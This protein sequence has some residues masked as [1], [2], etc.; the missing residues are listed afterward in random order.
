MSDSEEIELPGKEKRQ[1][2]KRKA[3]QDDDYGTESTAS[4]VSFSDESVSTTLSI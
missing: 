1:K 2:R 3:D 4:E